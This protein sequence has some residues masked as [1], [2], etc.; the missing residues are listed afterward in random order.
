[1]S[2]LAI[3]PADFIVGTFIVGVVGSVTYLLIAA[4][5]P[6]GPDGR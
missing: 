1:M 4:S 5:N 6:R 3:A 2:V